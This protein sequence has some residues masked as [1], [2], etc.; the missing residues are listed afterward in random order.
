[1]RA[2]RL[3]LAVAGCAAGLLML[4]AGAGARAYD[5]H[6]YRVTSVNLEHRVETKVDGQPRPDEGAALD[7]TATW[8]TRFRGPVGAF[9]YARTS[10]NAAFLRITMQGS[11]TARVNATTTQRGSWTETTIRTAEDN[12][13]NRYPVTE[14]RTGTCDGSDSVRTSVAGVFRRSGGL[15]RF[16]LTPPQVPVTLPACGIQPRG[17]DAGFYTASARVRAGGGARMLR[18]SYRGSRRYT[19]DGAVVDETRSLTGT[20]TM[21]RVKFCPFRRGGNQFGCVGQNVDGLG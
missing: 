12:A 8:S 18:V 15:Y 21:R 2:P 16:Q 20:I 17:R 14:T 13:G 3:L 7:G 1:M 11:L 9:G 19:E 5:V 10:R 6:I 4:P